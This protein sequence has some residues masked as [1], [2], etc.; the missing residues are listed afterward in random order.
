MEIME[1]GSMIMP[2]DIRAEAT[3]TSISRKGM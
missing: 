1:G 3:T 2:M